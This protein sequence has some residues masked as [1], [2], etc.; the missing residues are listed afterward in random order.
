MKIWQNKP[1]NKEFFEVLKTSGVFWYVSFG[2]KAYP[3]PVQQIEDIKIMVAQSQ[4]KLVLTHEKIEKGTQAEVL[5]GPMQG[6]QGEI[7][8]IHGQYRIV[9][10]IESL[11]CCLFVNIDKENLRLLKTEEKQGQNRLRA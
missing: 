1:S 4:N 10:R 3:I 5:Y 8:E 2:G 11:G 7:V 9:I 6:M